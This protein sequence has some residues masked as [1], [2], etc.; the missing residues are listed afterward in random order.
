MQWN[1]AQLVQSPKASTEPLFPPRRMESALVAPGD[2]VTIDWPMDDGSTKPFA[3][4]VT[5][6][7]ASRRKRHGERFRYTIRFVGGDVR[8]SRLRHLTWR[9]NSAHDARAGQLLPDGERDDAAGHA[10]EPKKLVRNDEG[11][12]GDGEGAEGG[13]KGAECGGEGA[14]G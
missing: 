2:H 8:K 1:K 14:A 9:L 6:C 7:K 13:G 4:V 11:A 5:H 12:E 3:G 10:L